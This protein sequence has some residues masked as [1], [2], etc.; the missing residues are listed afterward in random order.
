MS[1][2]FRAEEDVQRDID[3]YWDNYAIRLGISDE[4]QNLVR[5]LVQDLEYARLAVVDRDAAV[6]RWIT[7]ARYAND[8]RSV[9]GN[10]KDAPK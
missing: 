10:P 3:D 7:S 8:P 2:E 1:A 4:V 5:R 6:Q 9:S